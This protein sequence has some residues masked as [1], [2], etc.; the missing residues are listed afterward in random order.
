MKS[1]LKNLFLVATA[2]VAI[3]GG[4][5]RSDAATWTIG[6]YNFIYSTSTQKNYITQIKNLGYITKAWNAAYYVTG[7]TTSNKINVTFYSKNDNKGGYAT[8][9]NFWIN[10]YYGVNLKYVGDTIAHETTH[11]LFDYAVN[12]RY[13]S[14]SSV[15]K[16]S[17]YYFLTEALAFYAGSVAFGG[18]SASSIKADIKSWRSQTGVNLTWWGCG[19]NYEF[20]YQSSYNIPVNRYRQAIAQLKAA[21]W[22]LTGGR[23]TSTAPAIKGLL[24]Y[25]KAGTYYNGYYLRG[26]DSAFCAFYEN[27]FKY[28]YGKYANM[29]ASKQG[30]W[31][32]TAYLSGLYYNSWLK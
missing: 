25:L 9:G 14:Y 2:L 27:A 15:K 7:T 21:G 23:T 30:G 26:S 10:T 22:F 29:D 8:G 1:N 19:Y 12:N 17:Y 3:S 31:F 18:A 6:H 13:W 5:T 28:A 16:L 20:Y 4:F 24:A 32:S 11:V